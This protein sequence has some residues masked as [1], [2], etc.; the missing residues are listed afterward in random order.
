[1]GFFDKNKI[2]DKIFNAKKLVQNKSQDITKKIIDSSP[3][4][5]NENNNDNDG[6]KY[7]N[8]V[9][10]DREMQRHNIEMQKQQ[11]VIDN[12]DAMLQER[13]NER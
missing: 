1:M 9:Y 4:G 7:N 5:P 8:V 2:S 10:I 11:E 6:I 12:L 13:I 3:L